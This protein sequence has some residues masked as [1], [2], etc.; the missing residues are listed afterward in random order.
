MR[1]CC[2]SLLSLK[3]CKDV[4]L[5]TLL[6]SDSLKWWWVHEKKDLRISKANNFSSLLC[7]YLVIP[8]ADVKAVTNSNQYSFFSLS[9]SVQ[10]CMFY[11]LLIKLL[12]ESLYL[13]M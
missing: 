13:K 7:E 12:M 8:E 4:C 2:K 6:L 9:I 3:L 10:P 1:L 5:M 11:M